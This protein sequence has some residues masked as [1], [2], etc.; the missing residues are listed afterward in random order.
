[1]KTDIWKYG[2]L[3]LK[4]AFA[5]GIIYYLCATGK[6]DLAKVSEVLERKTLALHGV[7]SLLAIYALMAVRWLC[8]LRWQGVPAPWTS[9]VR[10]QCIGIFFSSFM[11][12]AVGGDLVKAYY[13]ARENK[14]HR[15]RAILSI[16]VDRLVGLETLMIVSFV[17]LLVNY[18]LVLANGTLQ[19]MAISIG[20]YLAASGVGLA[21]IWSG[22]ARRRVEGL[23]VVRR[24]R[25]RPD[26]H[27][28]LRVYDA[29]NS[30]A[31]QKTH[32]LMVLGITVLIDILLVLLFFAIGREMGESA[33]SLSSYFTAVPVGI[34]ATT[35]PITPGGIGVGQG[36]FYAIFLLFGASSGS[37]GVTIISVY[38]VIALMVNMCFLVAY[39]GDRSSLR[40]APPREE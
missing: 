13:I 40:A 37:V 25:S 3:S 20:G 12:G 28:L 36:A 17:A 9:V 21:V 4:Y 39:I 26:G 35:L 18:R 5:G 1:V 6:L 29:L 2:I 27:P 23:A 11:P 22:A 33:L 30:Y 16:V 7:L 38:Q 8:L 14:S 32:L 31:D 15:T 10:I 19:V 34:L 24:L